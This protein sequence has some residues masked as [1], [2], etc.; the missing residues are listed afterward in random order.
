MMRGTDV[1]IL[2]EDEVLWLYRF[3]RSL[4]DETLNADIDVNVFSLRT[5]MRE[6]LNREKDYV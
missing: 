3:L 6:F 1:L 4:S 5:N 2:S